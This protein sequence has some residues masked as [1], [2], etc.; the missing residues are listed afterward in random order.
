[1]TAWKTFHM[2]HLLLSMVF[3]VIRTHFFEEFN[4]SL[5]LQLLQRTLEKV[6]KK[7]YFNLL[8]AISFC[9]IEERNGCNFS[10]E[11]SK[12]MSYWPNLILISLIA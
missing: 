2:Y 5:N 12:N 3:K 1:M 11:S 9:S 6:W 4:L 10:N 7:L 8:F